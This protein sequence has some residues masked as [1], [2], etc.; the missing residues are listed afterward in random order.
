M[1]GPP[2]TGKTLLAKAVDGEANVP[3]F[4]FSAASF[5][6]KYVGVGESLIRL[7]ILIANFFSPSIIFIDELDGFIS[8]ESS[9]NRQ[10][11]NELLTQMN[12]FESNHHKGIIVI[13]ASIR[14]FDLDQALLL[15]DNLTA[16]LKSICQI[17]IK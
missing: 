4:G 13:D 17:L 3:F 9:N 11:I 1:Y 7:L 14:I 8:I 2:G 15:P 12:G 16:K 10:T 5:D 6:E